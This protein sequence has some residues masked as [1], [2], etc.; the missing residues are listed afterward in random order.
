MH[1][2][3]IAEASKFQLETPCITFDQ[4]LWL[5]ATCLIQEEKLPIVC[6]LG[7]FHTLCYLHSVGALMKGSGLQDL[8]GEVYAENSV[9]RLISGK[10]IARSI[11]ARTLAESALMTLLLEKLIEDKKVDCERLQSYYEKA[12]TCEF[13]VSTFDEMISSNTFIAI[14]NE[15][16]ELKTKLKAKSRTAKLWLL[17]LDYISVAK[18]FILA[19]RTSDW[20]LHLD[21]VT[22]MLNLFA[23]TGHRNYAKSACLYVQEMKKLPPT[24]PWLYAQFVNEQ[25]TVKIGPVKIGLEFGPICPLNKHL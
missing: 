25:H 17:C 24:N 23:S 11:R 18:L 13:N 15:V 16:E 21:A 12:L 2:F 9:T 4:P 8:F 10:A 7:G 6:R 1:I 14:A 3:D 19:E 20:E 5:K 22:E